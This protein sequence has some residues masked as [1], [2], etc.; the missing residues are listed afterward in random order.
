MVFLI[1]VRRN[2][3]QIPTIGDAFSVEVERLIHRPVLPPGLLK[4]ECAR[5]LFE[6]LFACRG[7]RRGEEGWG[8]VHALVL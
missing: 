6:K 2:A 8:I 1:P 4:S 5:D 3:R 7:R